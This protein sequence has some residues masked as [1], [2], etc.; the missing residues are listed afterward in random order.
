MDN[1]G[2]KLTADISEFKNKIKEAGEESEKVAKK[3]QSNLDMRKVNTAIGIKPK[4]TEHYNF[5]QYTKI[6][7][8]QKKSGIKDL[9]VEFGSLTNSMKLFNNEV[10]NINTSKLDTISKMRFG[11]SWFKG[12]GNFKLYQEKMSSDSADIGG[13]LERQSDEVTEFGKSLQQNSSFWDENTQKAEQYDN[14]LINISKDHEEVDKSASKISGEISKAFTKGLKSVKRLTIGFLGARSAFML[15]RKYLGEYSRQNE[16]FAAKMQLTTGVITNA[17]APA[18][19]W[20]GNVIQ[21][22]V[23]GLARIIEL[24]TGVNILGKTVDNSLKGASESAK[25]LN[26]NLSGL[27]EISNIDT[28]ASGLSTGLQSQLN[29]LDEFQK[30][31]KEVD[32]WFKK[33][34]IDKAILGIRDALKELWGWITEHPFL[35]GAFVVGLLTFK[36]VII[37]ALVSKIAGTGG[38]GGALSLLGAFKALIAVGVVAWVTDTVNSMDKEF[39]KIEDEA[40]KVQE[41]ADN[42]IDALR[43]KKNYYEDTS[44]YGDYEETKQKSI[45]MYDMLAEQKQKLAKRVNLWTWIFEPSEYYNLKDQIKEIDDKMGTIVTETNKITIGYEATNKKIG[46]SVKLTDNMQKKLEKANEKAKLI[47][48]NSKI[49]LKLNTT[50]AD[51]QMKQW[52]NKWKNFNIGVSSSGSLKLPSYD[53]GTDYVSKDQIALIHEGERIIPKQYN[54]SEYLGQLGN[55]ETNMLLM[56]LNRS[57]LEFANRPQTLNVNGKELAKVTY[58]DYQEEGS[59]RGTNT[60]IR[61]V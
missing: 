53:V 31:I 37:P 2:V 17:L 47:K 19:E 29:A 9:V 48:D 35:T 44:E 38:T 34:G 10:E 43:E 33:Y 5:N 55:S 21:Y 40:N 4:E 58:S 20:F 11:E 32:E 54:N 30:K 46:E 52:V 1:Y 39:T 15:F 7:D 56:E 25:E 16:E 28:D 27:D 13:I 51:N 60:S 6:M 59:R 57:I 3:I 8:L 14:A 49:D 12:V 36:D 22:A 42:W 50:E 18:F 24:L 45:K 61:R 41:L 26:D 23:I